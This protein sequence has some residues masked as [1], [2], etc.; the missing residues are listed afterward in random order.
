MTYGGRMDDDQH[1]MR[2]YR[3]TIRGLY[4]TALLL[5][6]WV[7]WDQVK[8]SPEGI[9]IRQRAQAAADRVMAPVREQQ[10]FRK[11]AN[12]VVYEAVTIVEE[13]ADDD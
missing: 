5:N 10:M 2:V 7:L 11:A 13:S 1:S 12:A 8:D 6:A 3:W 4:L 9:A